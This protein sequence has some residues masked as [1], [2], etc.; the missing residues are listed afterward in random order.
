MEILK[1]EGITKDFPGVR[2]LDHVDFE[3]QKGEIHGIVGENGAG[4]STFV[5]I[6][7]GVYPPTEGKIFIDGK[8]VSFSSPKDAHR[9]IGVVHQERELVPTFTGAQNLFLGQEVSKLGFVQQK[10][11]Y[12]LGKEFVKRFDLPVELDVPVR[13]LSSGKQELI[14]ILKVLFR[15][16]PVLIFDEPTASLSVKEAEALFRLIRSLK[17][18]GVSVIYISHNLQEVLSLCDR[19]TV[20]RNGKKVATNDASS[21]TQATL[22][23]HMIAKDLEHQYPK[24]FI[25]VGSEVFRVENYTCMD[26]HLTHISFHIKGGEIVGFA[27]LVG[28]GRTELAKAIYTGHPY[29]EGALFLK[30]K[31]IKIGSVRNAIKNGIVMIPENRREEGII[32]TFSVEENLTLP[33]MREVSV[34]G[35]KQQ[36]KIEELVSRIIQA[37]SIRLVSPKQRI[38]KLSGGNQ[39]KVSLGKWLEKDAVLWIFDE[40]TQGIDVETK[41][42]IYT[43]MGDLASKGAGIWFISSDLRELT[44]ISDRIY[45]MC[46][47]TIVDEFQRPFDMEKILRAMHGKEA[48]EGIHAF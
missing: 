38:T 25:P 30:G 12:R 18:E 14:T 46:A 2:A 21:L 24:R 19:I 16:P 33:N 44:A 10:Q 27:G 17:T 1:T 40:P 13:E 39:Q 26:F 43:I 23:R 41:S 15:K 3:L 31:P 9:L 6:L 7:S 36:R 11:I 37:L 4:K 45:V 5:K 32:G 42:E 28:S 29:D 8:S 22:I 48:S 35:F 34:Y 47:S 20:F